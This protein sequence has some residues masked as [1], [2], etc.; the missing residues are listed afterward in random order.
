V[1][2][3]DV[4]AGESLGRRAD[5]TV[6]GTRHKRATTA[7]EYPRLG[8]DRSA[9]LD[10]KL[11][12]RAGHLRPALPR[13]LGELSLVECGSLLLV[14]RRFEPDGV[15]G[16]VEPRRLQGLFEILE[17]LVAIHAYPLRPCRQRAEVDRSPA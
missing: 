4:H 5:R 17:G 3:V 8:L 15:A 9:Q 14:H 12:E 16:Y 1:L 6:P 7:F 2:R 13:N 10:L 11:L